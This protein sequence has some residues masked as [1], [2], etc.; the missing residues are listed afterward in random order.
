MSVYRANT[1]FLL[2]TICLGSMNHVNTAFRKIISLYLLHSISINMLLFSLSTVSSL[3]C[4]WTLLMSSMMRLYGGQVHALCHVCFIICL[5]QF[6][7]KE[8]LSHICYNGFALHSVLSHL[9]VFLQILFELL[10]EGGSVKEI[11]EKK[12]L[13]QVSISINNY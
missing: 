12:D 1:L 5:H 4:R 8:K 10:A 6:E 11:I 2:Y 13:V 3:V 9:F 7:K